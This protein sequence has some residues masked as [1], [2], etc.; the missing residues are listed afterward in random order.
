MAQ[1][2]EH[3]SP[4]PRVG[5]SSLSSRASQ[6]IKTYILHKNK[7]KKFFNPFILISSENIFIFA[8][9]HIYLCTILVEMAEE[10]KNLLTTFEARLRQLIYQYEQ[11]QQENNRLNKLLVAKD[12][13]IGKLTDSKNKLEVMYT[14][15]RTAKTISIHDKDVV[16]TKK[17][18]L[19]LVREVDRCIALLKE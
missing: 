19:K 18:L 17:R 7:Y 11:L 8:S 13:E 14:N 4:K 6:R 3:R 12:E 1:L 10:D 9:N 15:L 2:V 5:S 16:D